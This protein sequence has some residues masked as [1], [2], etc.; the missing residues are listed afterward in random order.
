M[1]CLKEN[2]VKLATFLL[3]KKAEGWWVSIK[4]RRRDTYVMSLIGFQEIFEVN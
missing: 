1:E 4:A 3:Q 2:K